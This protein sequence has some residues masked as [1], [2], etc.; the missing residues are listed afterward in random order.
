[1]S[2]ES[3][4]LLPIG[5]FARATGLTVKALR[6]YAEIGVLRPT[7]VDATTGYRY[8]A[9]T[10]TRTAAVIA[11]L[12]AFDIPLAEVAVL[13]ETDD[14]T[15]RERLKAHRR[16]LADGLA[17]ARRI[18]DELDRVIA[19]EEDLVSKMATPQLSVTN[20]PA[21]RLVVLRGRV[22]MEQ[23]TQVIP[24]RIGE[25]AAW[26]GPNGGWIGA[27]MAVVGS[28]DEDDV[29]DLDV[30]WPVAEQVDPPAPFEVVTH[31]PTRAVVHRHIGP[32]ENVH[33]T[34]ALLEHAMAAAGLRPTAPPRESYETDPAEEPDRQKW[35]TEI[36]WPVSGSAAVADR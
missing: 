32:G 20:V 7:R 18:V 1:M 27:P 26:V 33:Q 6:H 21:R 31:P 4:S 2:A 5:R 22:P 24:Q 35:V 13:L 12:R 23:L 11:R 34:Y 29:V 19:T 8:Y 16:V 25:T 3:D 28:P 36:V 10:Q 15:L 9:L 14:D 17:D 30:G